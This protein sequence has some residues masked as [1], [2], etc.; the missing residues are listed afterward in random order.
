MAIPI[1]AVLLLLVMPL[2]ISEFRLDLLAKYLCFAFRAVG[3]VLIWGYGG[4]LSA[5]GR[6]CSSAW[7]AT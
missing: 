4:I 3:I 6:A 7:A 1:L 5:S 2:F